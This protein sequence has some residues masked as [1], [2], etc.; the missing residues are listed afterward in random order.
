[1]ALTPT[2]EAQL[3]QLLAEQAE[4]LNLAA[5]ET[6][7][8]S[9]LGAQKKNLGQLTA[10]SS[11]NDSDLMFVRQGTSDKSLILSQLKPYLDK[12]TVTM[13]GASRGLKSSATGTVAPVTIAADEVI[14]GDGAGNCQSLRSW[15]GS[16][17]LAVAGEN[18]LD[19]GTSSASTW[20]HVYAISKA[21][22]TKAFVASLSATS[23]TLPVGYTKWAYLFPIRTD[24][25]VNKYP[26]SFTYNG[27]VRVWQYKIATGSNVASLP[28]MSSG[29]NGNATTPTFVAVAVSAFVPT[30]A[31]EIDVVAGGAGGAVA[32]IVA[33]NTSF[34]GLGSVTNPCPMVQ[35]VSNSTNANR[36]ITLESTNIHWAC[37]QAAGYLACAGF[38]I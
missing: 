25:S 11:L 26:L 10:A 21:D 37:N 35:Q 34:G 24:A 14:T 4:L 1:M 38:T 2:E 36:R 22:G 30:N 29:I 5:N 7:I 32:F 6:T 8:I 18:G 15:S 20:Y 19:T 16:V 17:S 28:F 33:P 9:K 27:D 3:R 13:Q 23:P 31:K 12:A